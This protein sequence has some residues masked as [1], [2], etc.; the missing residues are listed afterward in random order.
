M[1]SKSGKNKKVTREPQV[2]V[3][4]M[5]LPHFDVFCDLLLNRPMAAWNL[6]VS[7]NVQT[8]KSD[9]YLPRVARLFEDLY[10]FGHFVIVINQT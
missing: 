2:S 10:Q 6:F 5:F 8:R 1:L 3:S 7:Y 4:L 9:I